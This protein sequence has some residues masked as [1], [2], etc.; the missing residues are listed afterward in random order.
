MEYEFK[1]SIYGFEMVNGQ[2]KIVISQIQ[3]YDKATGKFIKNGKL[4]KMLP[5]LSKHPVS[6]KPLKDEQVS[7]END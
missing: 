7:N 4:E 2:P 3:A 1:V 6:F 5:L